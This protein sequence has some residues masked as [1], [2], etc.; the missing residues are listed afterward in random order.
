MTRQSSRVKQ[1]ELASA[2]GAGVLGLGLGA[3]FAAHVRPYLVLTFA[4]G[5]LLHGWGMW[6]KHRLEADA[7]ALMPRWA[8]VLYWICWLALAGL[9]L[10]L[11]RALL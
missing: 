9:A 2:I 5:A 1:A 10:Y 4:V 8:R 6:D 7:D 11:G 3:L